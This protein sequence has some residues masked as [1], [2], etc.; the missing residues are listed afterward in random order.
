MI[1]VSAVMWKKKKKKKALPD[2]CVGPDCMQTHTLTS[3][4]YDLDFIGET[5]LYL[6]LQVHL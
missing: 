3:C 4:M 2:V 1:V 6:S 5:G